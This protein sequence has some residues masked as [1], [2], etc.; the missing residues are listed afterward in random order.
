[1]H[2]DS[3]VVP[4]DRGAR[5]PA[6]PA[7]SLPPAPVV[8]LDFGAALDSRPLRWL[9]VAACAVTGVLLIPILCLALFPVSV[10]AVFLTPFAGA[11]YAATFAPRGQRR[12]R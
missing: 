7:D 2:F 12:A 11:L 10:L 1:M 4:V 6:P 3:M 9:P 5:E 8:V